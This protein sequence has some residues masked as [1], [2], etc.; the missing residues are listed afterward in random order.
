MRRRLLVPSRLALR[1]ALRPSPETVDSRAMVLAL[2]L[3][4]FTGWP[5]WAERSASSASAS[6]SHI[7]GGAAH[8][9]EE[10]E[11]CGGHWCYR[12]CY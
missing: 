7:H 9:Y 8:L 12:L 6:W 4:G 3:A 10:E 11:W 5:S 2:V 1:V